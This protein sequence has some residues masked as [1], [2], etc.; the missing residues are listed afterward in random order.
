MKKV[1]VFF[2][3]VVC[4]LC[5]ISVVNASDDGIMQIN[6]EAS[7]D[8]CL[9]GSASCRLTENLSLSS[10]KI[11]KGDLVLDLNGYTIT[12]ESNLVLHSGF[13]NVERGAKLT[14]NDSTGSGKI[15]TGASGDVWAAIQ[16]IKEDDSN[17][18]AELKVN[19]GTIEGYY[20]G[21]VGNGKRNNTK[22]TINNGLIKCTNTED[23]T[24]IFQP[25]TGDLIINNGTITG[26]TGIEI[27][28]GNLT[29]YNG[30]I[31]GLDEKFS[32]M[33]NDSGTTTDG[34]GIAV[35]QHTTNHPIN[36]TIHAGD[37]SGQYAFYEWN[38]QKNSKEDL[39]KITLLI[40]G[41]NFTGLADGVQ[42]IYSE[43]FTKF[44]S[45][46]KFNTSIKEY[47]TEDASVVSKIIEDVNKSEKKWRLWMYVLPILVI[48]IG[49]LAFL[50]MKIQSISFPYFK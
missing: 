42:T 18:L 24:G 16:L 14:I 6:D 21:I 25:Q 5:N 10:Q 44:V 17:K 33:S 40:N 32:K 1:N 3:L 9:T 26:G 48:S 34:V 49:I 2:A 37:I 28:S 8:K 35:A 50:K 45:G 23:C 29:V 27:R 20:Y 7:F 11:V 30:T 19:G 38:P 46:G 22:I 41:G 12:P 4:L 13:I 39:D 31:K 47:L 15:S 36:V 43:D